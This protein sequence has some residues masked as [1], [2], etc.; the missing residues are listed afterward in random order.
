MKL[1]VLLLLFSSSLLRAEGAVTFSPVQKEVLTID[2]S[3]PAEFKDQKILIQGK[4]GK[5]Q[6][7][8]DRTK[9]RI[10]PRDKKVVYRQTKKIDCDEDKAGSKTAKADDAPVFKRHTIS[11]LVGQGTTGLETRAKENSDLEVVQK[12][13]LIFGA[14]Y[15]YHWDE[16]WSLT[17]MVT[18][19]NSIL[20]G[21]GYSFN[22]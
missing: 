13:G 6:G 1:L 12:K 16:D 19:N 3:Y 20:A 8:F 7:E 22:L 21:A 4:D 5:S 11:L 17:G 2:D 9:W 10:V 18:S 15:A 14:Q